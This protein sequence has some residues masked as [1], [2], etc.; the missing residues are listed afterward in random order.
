[1]SR[2]IGQFDCHQY[3]YIHDGTCD[4]LPSSLPTASTPTAQ[5]ASPLGADSLCELLDGGIDIEVMPDRSSYVAGGMCIVIRKGLLLDVLT[6][7]AN[8]VISTYLS[9]SLIPPSI[10][11]SI[12]LSM[13][14]HSVIANNCNITSVDC[15]Q[16]PYYNMSTQ[17]EVLAYVAAINAYYGF[18]AVTELTYL[19][20]LC[21]EAN[22]GIDVEYSTVGSDNWGIHGYMW[23]LSEPQLCKNGD[24][25][26]SPYEIY[27]RDGFEAD[28]SASSFDIDNF[29]E[30]DSVPMSLS[31]HGSYLNVLTGLDVYEG[32][33]TLDVEYRNSLSTFS[34]DHSFEVTIIPNDD[35][36][37]SDGVILDLSNTDKQYDIINRFSFFPF[38]IDNS[39]TLDIHA[40]AKLLLGDD[41][42]VGAAMKEVLAEHMTAVKAAAVQ[43]IVRDDTVTIF[44]DFF[45][46]YEWRCYNPTYKHTLSL[47]GAY[48]MLAPN[49][50]LD[51][52]YDCSLSTT[53][54]NATNTKSYFSFNSHTTTIPISLDSGDLLAQ[55]ASPGERVVLSACDASTSVFNSLVDVDIEGMLE[56]DGGTVTDNTQF[57]WYVYRED[58]TITYSYRGCSLSFSIPQVVHNNS[59]LR[60]DLMMWD[61]TK[62][63]SSTLSV[64]VRVSAGAVE[65][66][67]SGYDSSQNSMLY[68]SYNS[69]VYIYGDSNSRESKAVNFMSFVTNARHEDIEFEWNIEG[70]TQ[71]EL[72]EVFDEY[73]TEFEQVEQSNVSTTSPFFSI[74]STILTSL[75]PESATRD[76]SLTITDLRE[77]EE[78]PNRT[79]VVTFPF[80]HVHSI[81]VDS[82]GVYY[83]NSGTWIPIESAPT[84]TCGQTQ[85]KIA[86]KKLRNADDSAVYWSIFLMDELYMQGLHDMEVTFV[87]PCAML[88]NDY[89]S[90][91]P[92]TMISLAGTDGSGVVTDIP[93]DLYVGSGSD[94]YYKQ[95]LTIPKVGFPQPSGDTY[96]PDEVFAFDLAEVAKLS[97]SVFEHIHRGD[98]DSYATGVIVAGKIIAS[99]NQTLLTYATLGQLTAVEILSKISTMLEIASL[100]NGFTRGYN[101]YLVAHPAYN[102]YL[103][104]ITNHRATLMYNTAATMS[105]MVYAQIKITTENVIIPTCEAV[106]AVDP[107]N[108]AVTNLLLFVEVSMMQSFANADIL[109]LEALSVFPLIITTYSHTRRIADM[110]LVGCAALDDAVDNET[111]GYEFETV[112]RNFFEL[113]TQQLFPGEF[114]E[115]T[116][117]S[118][119]Y[120][121]SLTP[122]YEIVGKELAMYNDDSVFNCILQFSVDESEE[123]SSELTDTEIM[124]IAFRRFGVAVGV[125]AA[126]MPWQSNL[127]LPS[128]GDLVND[129]PFFYSTPL[130]MLNVN[131]L[132]KPNTTSTLVQYSQEDITEY[133]DIYLD[134]MP[135]H[136][137]ESCSDD[138]TLCA[139]EY[140]TLTLNEKKTTKYASYSSEESLSSTGTYYDLESY[141]K[142]IS[143]EYA[144]YS[145][146]HVCVVE[147]G[148]WGEGKVELYD[149]KVVT[150]MLESSSSEDENST[151]IVFLMCHILASED[152][153][154]YGIVVVEEEEREWKIYVI[155][156]IAVLIGLGTIIGILV[157]TSKC[158]SRKK[159]RKIRQT[160]FN[161]IPDIPN[162]SSLD[163]G[164]DDGFEEH[165]R[166][167]EGESHH[168]NSQDEHSD[169]PIDHT[170]LQVRDINEV[171]GDFESVVNGGLL[172]GFME[173]AM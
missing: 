166:E 54:N 152:M 131:I 45:V 143:S 21:N 95:S 120:S 128:H 136:G 65:R 130:L 140:Y 28:L 27:V 154:V 80:T 78:S 113:N 119:Y 151:E 93:I 148:S 34:L 63:I 72:L 134:L 156:G 101:E 2:D 171:N 81:I 118:T 102:P 137:D 107:T 162:D 91:Y 15:I 157:L 51:G 58:E 161:N 99:Y 69:R 142:D 89:N 96:T 104:N 164:I 36:S 114:Y 155:A 39:A 90:L 79:A 84:P 11:T 13:L 41:F 59:T 46:Q 94:G 55:T 110:T 129:R 25:A 147:R 4:T 106:L 62:D 115:S 92:T 73:D 26:C 125:A 20:M 61:S 10:A 121:L 49:T 17:T 105:R 85:L 5:T 40:K 103:G 108:T 159:R 122:L 50:L 165:Q 67:V 18:E 14:P 29:V 150:K 109:A 8:D 98:V 173:G 83:N 48:L 38:D 43:G 170:E 167:G 97:V 141:S 158:L 32:S 139:S 47:T 23:S 53:F 144:H 117:E 135:D 24:D 87:L 33:I 111:Y 124:D 3:I 64:Y 76:I 123:N 7:S 160:K 133:V 74:P 153:K 77:D 6:E 35:F 146:K 168:G 100:L 31:I 12:P 44:D 66:P 145:L 16:Y 19:Q 127:Y 70:V 71:D 75:I 172:D 60:I 138:E 1:S 68:S 116:Q 57:Q 126:V 132:S 86:W 112:Y 22:K 56:D 37:C 9:T 42:E 88:V 149:G 30:G 82:P 169:G 52:R 163:I